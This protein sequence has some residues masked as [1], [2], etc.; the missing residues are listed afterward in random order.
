MPTLVLL[1]Y[2]QTQPCLDEGPVCAYASLGWLGLGLL[3]A[4]IGAAIAGGIIGGIGARRGASG[5]W[6][7]GG[8]IGAVGVPVGLS[9]PTTAPWL[10]MTAAIALGLPLLLGAGI[11]YARM[12]RR[13]PEP[14]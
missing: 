4:G 2:A 12:T 5:S 3:L 13:M 10:M 14:E 9:V 1:G 6:G 11:A 7:I 8:L